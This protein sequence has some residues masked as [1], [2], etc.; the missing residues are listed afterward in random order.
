MLTFTWRRELRFNLCPF[1]SFPQLSLNWSKRTDNSYGLILHLKVDTLPEFVVIYNSP[2]GWM[3]AIEGIFILLNNLMASGFKT[4][5]GGALSECDCLSNL[6]RFSFRTVCLVLFLRNS[7]LSLGQKHI[8]ILYFHPRDLKFCFWHINPWAIQ[9][10]Y[11][12]VVWMRIPNFIP[13][14]PVWS[15]IIT[16]FPAAFNK[17]SILYCFAM[18]SPCNKGPR[19]HVS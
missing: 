13:N 10:R 18:A 7:F 2:E 14:L 17:D 11:L 3:L 6:L 15:I 5:K 19:I 1:D 9:S 4:S 16:S 8:F 12:C